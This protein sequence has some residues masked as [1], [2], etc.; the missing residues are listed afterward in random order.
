MCAVDIP[1]NLERVRTLYPFIL[2]KTFSLSKMHIQNSKVHP[3]WWYFYVPCMQSRHCGAIF[4]GESPALPKILWLPAFCSRQVLTDV[5]E[6]G[7]K[8][9]YPTPC[10]EEPCP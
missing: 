10:P 7:V 9:R 1:V 3:P 4:K 6:N 2:Y 5:L 8:P